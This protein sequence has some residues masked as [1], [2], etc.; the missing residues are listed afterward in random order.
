MVIK[1][2]LFD[3][4]GV[5]INHKLL[6]KKLIHIFKPKNKEKFWN[7]VNIAV[8][9]LCKNEISEEFFWKNFAKTAGKNPKQI[10][11][12]LWIEDYEKLTKVNTA[13]IDIIKSLKQKYKLGLISNSIPFHTKINRKRGAYKL[14]NKVILSHKV[15]LTKDEK[16]IFKLA[17]NELKVKPQECIFVDDVKDFVNVAK[18]VSMKG[19]IF[20][21]SK[22]LKVDLEKLLNHKLR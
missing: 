19:I 2:I 14:F 12:N 8:I 13:V 6:V 21:N 16:N 5:V 9:P 20:K 1:A 7:D 11:K 17:V 10:P 4:G 18:S 15:G 3:S 22:Q